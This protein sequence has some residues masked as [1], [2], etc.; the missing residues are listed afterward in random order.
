[1]KSFFK[2][3]FKWFWRFSS[4]YV[5][6]ILLCLIKVDYCIYLPGNL[7]DVKNEIVIDDT[8]DLNGSVSSVYIISLNR[9]TLFSY[10]LTKDLKYASAVKLT[11]SEIKE[12]DNKLDTAIGNFDAM[13]SFSSAEVSAYYDLYKDTDYFKYKQV[14]YISSSESLIDANLKYTEIVG[15]LI[16][17][18]NGIEYPTLTE[19]SD[20]LKSISTDEYATL[21]LVN[22]KGT[23]KELKIKKREVDGNSLFGITIKTSFIL[24]IDSN[25]KVKNVYS[26]GPS[27]GAMQALY[28]YLKLNDEDL[29][30]GRKIAGTGTIGYALNSDGDIAT[31]SYIGAIGCVEQKLYAAFLDKAEV[32]YCPKS[33]YERCLEAYKRYGFTDKDIRLVEVETL[34][35]IIE[36]LKNN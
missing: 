23:T 21:N 16:K 30:R 7:T 8:K 28:I 24:D 34:S 27:G 14:T 11:K 5:I 26:Q 31:F 19:V 36:D 35:D 6:I 4:I 29:L 17:D 13:E 2:D 1:M 9:P 20:Y 15:C 18:L 32:F 3:F 12:M 22:S 10:L 33:N 25:I